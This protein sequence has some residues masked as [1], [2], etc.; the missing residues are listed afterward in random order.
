MAAAPSAKDFLTKATTSA[1]VL[2]WSRLG[3][4]SAGGFLPHRG[5]GEVIVGTGGVEN[6]SAKTA[7]GGRGLEIVFVFGEIFGHG[8]ELSPNV[9]PGIEHDFRWAVGAV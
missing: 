6:C 4:S 3:S 8:D 5:I 2:Y 1:L 9:V 7:L